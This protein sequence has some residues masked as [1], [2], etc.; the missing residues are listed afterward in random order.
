MTLFYACMLYYMWCH[1]PQLSEAT[2]RLSIKWEKFV[3]FLAQFRRYSINVIA[4]DWLSWERP[5]L[6]IVNISIPDDKTAAAPIYLRANKFSEDFM[7][8]VVMA[9]PGL[10]VISILS[11]IGV[12]VAFQLIHDGYIALDQLYLPLS[13][14]YDENTYKN[15]WQNDR[16]ISNFWSFSTQTRTP[17]DKS[18]L[19]GYFTLLIFES[20]SGTTFLSTTVMIC[21]I[22]LCFG[23]FSNAF[24]LHFESMF[25]TMSNVVDKNPTTDRMIKLKGTLIDAVKLHNLQKE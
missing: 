21:A 15:G 16:L 4:L 2:Y 1:S 20:V 23:T 14:R 12:G 6:L 10:Y 9:M 24:C 8:F 22:F 5:L 11:F 19:G 25:Q 17:F 7:K 13:I 3:T 18:T